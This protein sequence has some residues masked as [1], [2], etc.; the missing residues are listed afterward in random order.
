MKA[1]RLALCLA[2]GLTLCA[3]DS[4]TSRWSLRAT[5]P[6]DPE[7]FS[8][9]M[10]QSVGVKF[11]PGHQVELVNNG[12]LFDRLE[13]EIGRAQQ[14]V[15][16]VLFIWRPEEPSARITRALV[17]KAREGIKCRVIVDAVGS[18][19]FPEKVQ[20]A[21]E[22]AGCDVRIFRPLG[23]SPN[24]ERNH[25][26]IIVIDGKLGI[27]GGFGL[28]KPWLGDG[29]KPDEW[30]ETNA[31]IRG[32]AVEEMQ[33]AF[34]ENWQEVGGA[35]LPAED[36][37][38]PAKTDGTTL[39]AFVGSTTTPHLTR[40][41]R[42]TQLTLAAAKKRLWIANPYFVPS[43]GLIDLLVQ[44]QHE[45]VDVRVMA[46]GKNTDHKQILREQ[47]MTYG[48][49]LA[50]GIRIWEYEPSLLHA[51]TALVDDHLVM[52]GS[53]NMDKLSLDKMDEGTL[54]MSDP[55]LAKQLEAIWLDDI[56]YCKPVLKE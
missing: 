27:T 33:Q 25:R 11:R 13:E 19:D 50:A 45:G 18:F 47:R 31:L 24:L 29:R 9:A 6:S 26:K 2:A 46:A 42:I 52:L 8:L 38:P 30:R 14:S 10:Y 36:F 22:A 3:C 17:A 56:P 49:L 5:V 40:A 43:P 51:K 55:A 20:R 48:P 7:G 1:A 12:K 21:L 35:L 4:R 44:K 16:I 54:V 41:E 28:H 15:N 23:E 53:I 37:P 32:P 39:A 34:A